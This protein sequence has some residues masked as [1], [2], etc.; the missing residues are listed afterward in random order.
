M[1][2]EIQVKYKEKNYTVNVEEDNSIK[3]ENIKHIDKNA[4]G[5]AHYNLGDAFRKKVLADSEGILRTR[6]K[7][8]KEVRLVIK[9]PD[10]N[11][12]VVI[13]Q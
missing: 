1:A 3:L 13:D 4:V 12:T 7:W 11:K 5:L 10:T 2:T 6:E 8:L 9:E